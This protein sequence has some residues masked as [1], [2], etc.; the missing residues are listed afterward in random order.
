VSGLRHRRLVALAAFA[1]ALGLG[2]CL[3]PTRG[4]LVFVDTWA[5]DFWSG[6]GLLVEVS[7]DRRRCR[8]AVRDRALIVRDLWVDCERVHPR[9][10]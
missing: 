8:V 5:G 10:A 6:K 1:F 2:G 3:M 7:E 4:T 9:R